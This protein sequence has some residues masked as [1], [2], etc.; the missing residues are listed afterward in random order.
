MTTRYCTAI[1]MHTH[2]SNI[3]CLFLAWLGTASC[4]MPSFLA[5]S[6]LRLGSQGKGNEGQLRPSPALRGPQRGVLLMQERPRGEDN[7]L[8]GL[9][10]KQRFESNAEKNFINKRAGKEYL[11]RLEAKTPK[12][13]L[14]IGGK[15]KETRTLYLSEIE[16]GKYRKRTFMGT[17]DKDI[18]KIALPAVLNNMIIPL[19]GAVD[20][21]WVGRM[22]FFP[23]TP[24][25]LE[26]S[27]GC[28]V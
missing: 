12:K 10:K 3:A 4:F 5:P 17:E 14:P 9:S 25:Q 18:I 6:S 2:Y 27:C 21:F 19:V 16:K 22:V 23:Q 1:N 8:D 13:I 11:N 15:N 28:R 20:T 24:P 26:K 7:Y